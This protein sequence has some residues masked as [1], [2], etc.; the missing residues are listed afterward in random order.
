VGLKLR[1]RAALMLVPLSLIPLHPVASRAD[2]RCDEW[3][4]VPL[5][6]KGK[7]VQDSFDG[8]ASAGASVQVDRCLRT[9]ASR[10]ASEIDSGCRAG[11]ELAKLWEQSGFRWMV[12]CLVVAD[13]VAAGMRSSAKLRTEMRAAVQDCLDE[14]TKPK[15]CRQQLM[16]QHAAKIAG[17]R[18]ESECRRFQALPRESRLAEVEGRIHERFSA[19]PVVA[20]CMNAEASTIL[21]EFGSL[22]RRGID[23]SKAWSQVLGIHT[24]RCLGRDFGL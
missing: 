19:T 5:T 11:G 4:G 23:A 10:M 1:F 22:C 3:V 12:T 9:S 24:D 14:G 20:R 13:R 16:Q 18:S 7:A 15:V 6:Q 21:S 8:Q 17:D 2:E